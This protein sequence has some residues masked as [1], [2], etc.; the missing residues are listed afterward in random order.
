MS[1]SSPRILIY[2]LR[3][4]L[5]LADNP[6][7]HHLSKC[8]QESPPRFTHL[9]P[10]YV[11]HPGQIE[12]AGLLAPGQIS[13]F[14]EARSTLGA[15]WRTG[16]YRVQFL[17]ETLW[18]MDKELKALGSGLTMRVGKVGDVLREIIE[19]LQK[20]DDGAK[21]TGVYMTQDY[22]YEELQEERDVRTTTEGV[23]GGD[24][25]FQVLPDETHLID[26]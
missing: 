2:I 10:L 13:P 4:D 23:E 25:D 1:A 21:V 3:R 11:F 24:I 20:G 12:V 7:F 22:G 8:L 5:R 18:A 26:E 17:T 6:V 14:P 19:S 15:F 9:L 16:P